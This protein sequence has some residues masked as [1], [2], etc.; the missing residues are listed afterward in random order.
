MPGLILVVYLLFIT[1]K[2]KQQ[3]L[4]QTKAPMRETLDNQGLLKIVKAH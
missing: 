1:P 2:N 3:M 4:K